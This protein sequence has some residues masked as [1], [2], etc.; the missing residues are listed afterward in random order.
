MV[1]HD[2]CSE[3]GLS[4]F[5]SWPHH[6]CSYLARKEGRGFS[7]PHGMTGKA[8]PHF[9]YPTSLPSCH[10]HCPSHL[11]FPHTRAPL[12]THPTPPSP[13]LATV[14]IARSVQLQEIRR[15]ASG[16]PNSR[17]HSHSG[18]SPIGMTSPLSSLCR[19][20]LCCAN[21]GSRLGDPAGDGQLPVP[22]YLTPLSPPPSV[23]LSVSL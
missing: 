4:T 22:M 19:E 20:G 21:H 2:P 15:S 8:V 7:V 13:G 9:P 23:Y 1:P 5:P 17:A 14:L 12:H 6:T 10:Q 16:T 18:D 11:P 3:G